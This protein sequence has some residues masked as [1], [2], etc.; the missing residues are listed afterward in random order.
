MKNHGTFIIYL[1][2]NVSCKNVN[3]AAIFLFTAFGTIE[4]SAVSFISICAVSLTKFVLLIIYTQS[5]AIA[6]SLIILSNFSI[7]NYSLMQ[8]YIANFE[9]GF[10]MT[11][12]LRKV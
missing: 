8:S 11:F 12:D 10:S 6:A 9:R 3:T 1:V 7:T 2:E 4:I 5:P